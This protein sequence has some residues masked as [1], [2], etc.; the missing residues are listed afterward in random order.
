LRERFT[1]IKSP[2]LK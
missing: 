1:V 2:V